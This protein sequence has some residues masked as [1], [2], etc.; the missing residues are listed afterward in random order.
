MNG[1]EEL[2]DASDGHND[3]PNDENEASDFGDVEYWNRRYAQSCEPFEWYQRWEHIYP[4]ISGFICRTGWA[5]HLGCGSSAASVEL[6]R[7]FRAVVSIDI[8]PVVIA[9]M[10]LVCKDVANIEWRVM[11][12]TKM[13]LPDESFDFVLNKGTLDTL[14]CRLDGF[15]KVEETLREVCRLLKKGGFLVALSYGTPA[16]RVRTF[17]SYE[18][19]WR[20][21]EP[22]PIIGRDGL[23]YHHIYAFEKG[24]GRGS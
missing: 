12:C 14:F 22:I 9:H 8:S 15:A 11:D 13:D 6:A 3:P 20:L 2:A 4:V 17:G 21:H 24:D 19:P 18:L 16:S 5:L 1:V 23:G 10:K 7:V